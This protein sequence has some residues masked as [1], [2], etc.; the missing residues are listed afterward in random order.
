MANFKRIP[1]MV[2]AATGKQI[3]EFGS[4]VRDNDFFRLLFDETVILC[5]QFCDVSWVDGEAQLGVHPIASDLTLAAFG[6]NDFDYQTTF[7]FLSEQSE[8]DSNMVNIED[9]WFDGATADPANG[10]L[11]FR[12]DTNTTRFAEALNSSSIQKFY[13]CITGVPSGQTAKTVLAYF[14]FKAENRPSSSA[15]AP[16]SNDPEYLNAQEVQALVKSAPIFQFSVDGSTNWHDTQAD[17]DLYYREQRNGG[18]WSEAIKMIEIAPGV[19]VSTDGTLASN[20]DANIPTEKAVK[21]YADTKETALG[22][23]PED[24]ANKATDFT[25]VNNTLY[26]TVQAV[27]N[28]IDAAVVGLFDDRG[29]YDASVNT[30][31]ASG[32]SGDAGAILKGD[33]W[34]ISV[35]GTL[36]GVDV[37][38]G[39]QVRALSD[40]P[41]QTASNWTISEANIG[42]VPE[43]EAN[44]TITITSGSTDTQYPSAKSVYDNLVL[45]ADKES[46]V[47]TGT[48]EAQGV[49]NLSS[50]TYTFGSNGIVLGDL[51]SGICEY[52]DDIIGVY[53]NG[54][55]GYRFNSTQFYAVNGAALANVPA[56]ETVP[57]LVPD[58][59]DMNTGIGKKADDVLTAIAGGVAS[60]NFTVNGI[61]VPG[62]IKTDTISELTTGDGVTIDGCLVKDGK[63]ADVEG[64]SDAQWNADKVQGVTVDD[65]AK[66]DGKVLTYNSTS[67]NLEYATPPGSTGGE[68]NTA[69]NTGSSGL[70]IYKSKSG[71]DLQLYKLLG[72]NGVSITLNGTDYI[73][74]KL[75]TMTTQGDIIYGGADGAPTRLAKGTAGQILTMNPGATAPEWVDA[76]SGSASDSDI[77]AI[78]KHYISRN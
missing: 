66:A 31:P 58:N 49:L 23:T 44:K 70:G 35:A 72:S 41:G 67:G 26:T 34:T 2:D 18:E 76:S 24:V 46:P 32:G 65:A 62:A 9:D 74:V 14:R 15:G 63:V 68:A 77:I 43:N 20:S 3:D 56:S 38:I 51:D 27:K 40:A 6:D 75:D 61:E 55:W 7:M 19:A 10:Q 71:V 28:Y 64:K 60:C 13:F 16:V 39:D 8:D 69:S 73:D 50:T 29:N 17:D 11:S 22:F 52:A 30:F 25:T 53:L 47:F 42:Y 59:D 4:V 12:I 54:N 33:I 57:V 45:K 21:A 48:V 1:V 37:S 36:G 5:C 78:S